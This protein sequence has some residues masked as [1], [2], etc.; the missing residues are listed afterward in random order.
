[1]VYPDSV[2]ASSSD[3]SSSSSSSGGAGVA[4]DWSI[5]ELLGAP[6][7]L[8]GGLT[9]ANVQQA[10]TTPNV[11]G[12]DCSSGKIAHPHHSYCIYLLI[13]WRGTCL[14]CIP[15]TTYSHHSHTAYTDKTERYLYSI[16]DKRI[17]L[18]LI[19][20]C[21]CPVCAAIR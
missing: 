6:V 15:D 4:F 18:F 1:M 8:A 16:H 14:F 9:G 3:S 21:L 13:G 19:L 11:I 7:L 5:A 12:V 2:V 17:V 20:Y 10:L